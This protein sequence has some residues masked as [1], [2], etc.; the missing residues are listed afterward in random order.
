MTRDTQLTTLAQGRRM[1]VTKLDSCGRPVYGDGST[2]TSDG[3]VSVSAKL[4]TNDTDAIEVKNANGRRIIYKRASSSLSGYDIEIEMAEV[5]PELYGLMTGQPI[6]KDADGNFVG[7][8]A[9]SS[10]V[11]SEVSFALEVWAGLTGDE[12]CD[13]EDAEGSYGYF[14]YPFIQGGLVGD[15]EIQ[16]DAITFTLTDASTVDGNG[17][18]EGPYDVTLQPSVGGA[19]KQPGPLLEALSPTL[20]ELFIPVLVDPPEALA[21]SRPLLDPSDTVLTAVTPTAATPL[22]APVATLGTKTNGGSGFAA[23]T[24]YWKVTAIN[25]VGET[26]GSSEL[27][28]TLA[29]N[30]HQP[31]SWLAITGATGY[32]LYRGTATGAENHLIASV[33]AVTS[34]IDD[35][36]TGTVASVPTTNTTAHRVY[37]FS[38]TPDTAEGVGVWYEFGDGTWDFADS[39]GDITH[40]YE[41]AGTFTVQASSNGVWIS[42]P[43]TVS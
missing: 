40:Q 33:G 7:F 37:D 36:T 29:L 8:G 5:D 19:A 38:V 42:Q 32:K 21:G 13:D 39:P 17:W 35:G 26:V 4:A 14:L 18:G 25:D 34:V 23:G 22:A 11:S 27:T 20:H 6:F 12:G 2:V 31:I 28:A 43:V 10:V 24:Y 1:R 15:H 3:F 41:N 30:D 9:D 16:N